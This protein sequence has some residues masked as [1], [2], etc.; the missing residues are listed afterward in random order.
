MTIFLATDEDGLATREESAVWFQGESNRESSAVVATL[1]RSRAARDPARITEIVLGE[2]C[3]STAH[4]S[5][6]TA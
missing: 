4:R 5:A 3:C 2:I 1:E 6:F